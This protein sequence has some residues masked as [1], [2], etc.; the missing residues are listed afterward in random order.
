MHYIPV[1]VIQVHSP[2]GTIRPLRFRVDGRAID[3]GRII[4]SE[5]TRSVGGDMLVYNCETVDGDT[6]LRYRL[7]LDIKTRV[8][9]ASV[10]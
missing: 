8:W 4:S 7:V 9:K 6:L 5:Q 3:I 2:A 1:E 10:L